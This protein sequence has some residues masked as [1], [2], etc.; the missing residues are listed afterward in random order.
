MMMRILDQMTAKRTLTWFRPTTE[1]EFFLMRLAQK[2][3]E[4]AAV[5]HYAELARQHNDET[6]LLAYR[7][8]VNQGH[9]PQDLA[10]AFHR[11][12]ASIRRQDDRSHADRVLAIKVERRCVAVAVFVG[13]RLDFHDMRTLGAQ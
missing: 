13:T 4:P 9:L 10:A 2:L 11:E 6:L 8:T 1:R 3:G 7:K 5:E 12:L